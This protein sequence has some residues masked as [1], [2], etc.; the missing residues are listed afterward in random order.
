MGTYA[1][2]KKNFKILA[3]TQN[4]FRGLSIVDM[5]LMTILTILSRKILISKFERGRIDN[6]SGFIYG[7]ILFESDVKNSK[8]FDFVWA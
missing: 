4:R 2:R 8:L 7:N 3:I 6:F 1:F 5:N